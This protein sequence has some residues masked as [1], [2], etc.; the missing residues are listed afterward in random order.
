MV[1]TGVHHQEYRFLEEWLQGSRFSSTKADPFSRFRYHR[2]KPCPHCKALMLCYLLFSHKGIFRVPMTLGSTILFIYKYL[3]LLVWKSWPLSTLPF[4]LSHTP[5][6]L[7]CP[8]YV[9]SQSA[10]AYSCSCTLLS[11]TMSSGNVFHVK[12][13]SFGFLV[14][15]S[16][17]SLFTKSW[18][19]RKMII[20]HT[21]L[22]T[23]SPPKTSRHFLSHG[24]L[25]TLSRT[26]LKNGYFL[27]SR[28]FQSTYPFLPEISSTLWWVS[29][30]IVP[31]TPLSN[32]TLSVT[33]FLSNK[34]GQYTFLW[35][36]LSSTEGRYLSPRFLVD[37]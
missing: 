34:L 9:P 15:L 33:I 29:Y 24:T 31:L 30:N 35:E 27:N 11:K 16:P 25:T 22:S 37:Q 36:V 2:S 20:I 14:F 17:I 32:S 28:P 6:L 3:H 21:I 8:I 18:C 26:E 13:N 19:Q 23:L 1:S 12:K 10:I 4:H 7:Y 5:F